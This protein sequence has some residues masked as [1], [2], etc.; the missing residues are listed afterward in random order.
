MPG[1]ATRALLT[2][3]RGEATGR[4]SIGCVERGGGPEGAQEPIRAPQGP[5]REGKSPLLPNGCHM[6]RYNLNIHKRITAHISGPRE[7][8]SSFRKKF[9]FRRGISFN[10]RRGEFFF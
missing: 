9:K 4:R 10:Q 3:D 5:G 6:E 2:D 8:E 7:T 1:V